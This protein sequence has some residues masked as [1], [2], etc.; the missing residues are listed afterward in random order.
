MCMTYEQLRREYGL[1]QVDVLNIDAEGYDD[2]ILKSIDFEAS[3][4]GL[5]LFEVVH[6]GT[7]AKA[8]VFPDCASM[9]TFLRRWTWIA[10]QG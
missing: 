4:P 8:E 10:R 1:S 9:A 3:K 7:E 6:M 2:Q 5:I